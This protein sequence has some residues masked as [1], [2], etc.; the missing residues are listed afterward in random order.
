MRPCFWVLLKLPNEV[1]GPFSYARGLISNVSR[2]VFWALREHPTLKQSLNPP[3]N[4]C[5][6]HSNNFINDVKHYFEEATS[7]F[8]GYREFKVHSDSF[9]LWRQFNPESMS[10]VSR[11][12]LQ[13]IKCYDEVQLHPTI[14]AQCTQ[15]TSPTTICT[16]QCDA[17]LRI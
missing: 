4:T 2:H 17:V 7:G 1:C 16:S 11:G 10:N 15:T 13:I 14:L 5:S 12:A 9:E 6:M 3:V 8:D